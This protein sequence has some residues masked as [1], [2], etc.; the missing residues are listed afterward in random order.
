MKDVK[1]PSL[2]EKDYPTD[3]RKSGLSR[4]FAFVENFWY[5]HKFG[6]CVT[7]FLVAVLLICSFQMCG[8]NAYDTHILYAGP[9]F[10]CAGAS[11]IEAIESAFR[12]FMDDYNNDGQ[13]VVAYRPIWIMNEAQIQELKDKYKDNPEEAPYVNT[14]LL[15]QNADLLNSELMTGETVICLLDPSIFYRLYQEGWMEDLST[16]V[17]AENIPANSYE[18]HGVFLKDTDFGTYFSGLSEMPED[19]VLCIR[20]TSKLTNIWSPEESDRVQDYCKELMRRI[21]AFEAP[22]AE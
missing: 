6:T 22:E 10:D 19:T 9:W 2:P 20:R 18:N 1:E 11:R 5:H 13:K 15:A 12:Y 14:T 7:V 16:F 8:K 4:F 17:P 3:G 21:L